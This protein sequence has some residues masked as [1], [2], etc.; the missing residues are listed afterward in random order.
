MALSRAVCDFVD[1][2]DI[3]V[4]TRRDPGDDLAP[5]DARVN[6]GLATAAAVVDHHDEI[7]H[8]GDLTSPRGSIDRRH[9]F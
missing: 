3:A 2:A 6:D 9:Y 4:L 5:G 1:G 7:L 8:D